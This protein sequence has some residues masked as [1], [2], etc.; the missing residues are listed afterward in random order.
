MNEPEPGDLHAKKLALI[1]IAKRCFVRGLQTN[2]GGNLSVKLSG[3]DALLIKPSG[4][5]FNECTPDN[6]MV[7][8]FDANTLSGS[9]RPSKDL[10]FHAAL[11]R[12]RPDIGAIVHVHSPWATGLASAGVKL[13]CLTVQAVEKLGQVP[14]IGLAAGGRPQGP[15]QITAAMQD[16]KVKGAMLANHGTIG[17]GKTLLDAQYVVE[18]IEETAQI[19]FVRNASLHVQGKT[20][21]PGPSAGTADG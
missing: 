21:P 19:A 7:A 5:G 11:Y 17:L 12:A 20:A 1:S 13:P 15:A 8:D 14:L 2:A 18:I 6:L 16:N 4:V 9:G 3:V 10:G